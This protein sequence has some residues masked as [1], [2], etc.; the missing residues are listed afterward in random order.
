VILLC[1]VVDGGDRNF[2]ADEVAVER[3]EIGGAV[4][5]CCR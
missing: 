5:R 4:D 2:A 1:K 3:L